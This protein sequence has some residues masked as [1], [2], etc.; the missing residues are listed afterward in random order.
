MGY[1]RFEM[2]SGGVWWADGYTG[3]EFNREGQ[4]GDTNLGVI[5]DTERDALRSERRWEIEDIQ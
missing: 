3:L 2:R 1:V 5:T 4:A